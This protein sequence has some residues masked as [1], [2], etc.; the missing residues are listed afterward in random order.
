MVSDLL[1]LFLK[2]HVS[3][4]QIPAVLLT[5]LVT[6]FLL[7]APS[8]Q[9]SVL[10]KL[11]P[12]D[13]TIQKRFAPLSKLSNLA[14]FDVKSQLNQLY[15][16]FQPMW[17]RKNSPKSFGSVIAE[18]SNTQ[19]GSESMTSYTVPGSG[20]TH[21]KSD[22][23]VP[24]S[25]T[26][27][28]SSKLDTL[29]S[30]LFTSTDDDDKMMTSSSSSRSKRYFPDIP[31]SDHPVRTYSGRSVRD[32]ERDRDRDYDR[33]IDRDPPR[34]RK[35]RRRVRKRGRRPY[36]DDENRNYD[37]S[38][39]MSMSP[40]NFMSNMRQAVPFNIND[41]YGPFGPSPVLF[42]AKLADSMK[43][44]NQR[45]TDRTG[46]DSSQ[47]ASRTSSSQTGASPNMPFPFPFPLMFPPGMPPM[48]MIP[49][50]PPPFMHPI[51][52]M[53]PFAPFPMILSLATP[54]TTTTTTP[55]PARRVKEVA[56]PKTSIED[57]GSI[58]IAGIR[59]QSIVNKISD[60]VR[61]TGMNKVIGSALTSVLSQVKEA[62]T[63]VASQVAKNIGDSV[64]LSLVADGDSGPS[65]SGST[66]SSKA[67]KV[68]KLGEAK[69][70]FKPTNSGLSIS[71]GKE[72]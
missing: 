46:S 68:V 51:P 6:G 10:T 13:E 66:R 45:D 25:G 15:D 35:R 26:P 9:G 18:I 27:D 3:V 53:N 14:N 43:S 49:G 62:G 34:D 58:T 17:G 11:M 29:S 16:K 61:Q 21:I 22:S 12:S 70:S 36:R 1:L 48:P 69:I 52:G 7:A 72:R 59:P 64:S 33:D 57:D 44:P 28:S 38:F 50:M 60:V 41:P 37:Q 71:F 8:H 32:R 31:V 47:K 23:P 54:I 63:S 19:P 42:G 20:I 4:S 65:S 2:L 67:S 55:A 39:P 56:P 24:S 5:C 40:F 30:S